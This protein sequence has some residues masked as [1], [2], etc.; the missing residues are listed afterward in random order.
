MD[1]TTSAQNNSH[2]TVRFLAARLPRRDTADTPSVRARRI[3]QHEEFDLPLYQAALASDA[4]AIRKLCPQVSLKRAGVMIA[5]ARAFARISTGWDGDAFYTVAFDQTLG[6]W[7]RVLLFSGPVPVPHCAV[8]GR[9]SI[10]RL[11]DTPF[12]RRHSPDHLDRRAESL[13]S[14]PVVS[15]HCHTR[16]AAARDLPINH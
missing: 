13:F 15:G 12:C 11:R 2:S 6:V 7:R 5:T 9:P 1:D 8:C 16:P 10:Y 4:G 3:R 14:G